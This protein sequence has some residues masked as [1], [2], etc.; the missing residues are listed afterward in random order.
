MVTGVTFVNKCGIKYKF[1]EEEDA[2]MNEELI[3]NAPFPDISVEAPGM[4]TG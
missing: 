3:E 1:N 2:V 4:L